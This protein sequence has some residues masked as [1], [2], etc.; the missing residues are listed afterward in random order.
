MEEVA[1]EATNNEGKIYIE[2]LKL[3]KYYLEETKTS[4]GY[5]I[6]EERIE[7]DI[8]SDKKNV[9]ITVTNEPIKVFVPD[10]NISYEI[11]EFI[12]PKKKIIQK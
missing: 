5:Q 4:L 9:T 2:D 10:T 8:T 1:K 7:F 3:G 12:V 6:L 11:A